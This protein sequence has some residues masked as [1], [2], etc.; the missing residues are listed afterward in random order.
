ML[1]RLVFLALACTTLPAHA[2][3]ARLALAL[4]DGDAMAV[5]AALAS[6]S[7]LDQPF[8][9]SSLTP[10]GLAILQGDV[11][12]TRQ[13]LEAGAGVDRAS[14][15]EMPPL[16]IAA[17]SCLA[18]PAMI[19]LLLDH[20]AAIDSPA[21]GGMTPLL[22]AGL[23]GRDDIVARLLQAGADAAAVD[24]FGDGLLNFAI[25]SQ[26]PKRVQTAL[27][28]GSGTAQLDR[29]FLTR[30]YRA[31]FWPGPVLCPPAD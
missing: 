21:P 12:I 9:G 31:Y 30:G 14:A 8:A 7:D 4:R 20:G 29:L 11:G 28:F 25:Y 18:G 1:N 24:V 6:V 22:I 19:D 10:L 17:Y 13:L 2:D 23:K 3:E 15:L 5:T 16:A 26:D 27:A